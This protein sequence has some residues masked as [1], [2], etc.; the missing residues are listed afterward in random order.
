MA[1][2]KAQANEREYVIPL[3]NE[4]R[5]VANYRRAGRASK[6][7]KKFIAR[8]MRVED[9]DVSKVKLDRYLNNEVW[10]RGKT[11]PP[12]KLKVKA[13]RDG[14]VIRVELAQMPDTHKFAKSRHD[15]RHKEPETK[16]AAPVKQE[17]KEETSEEKKEEQKEKAQAAA[18]L[19]AKQAKQDAKAQE[20]ATSVKEPGYHRQA[21]KK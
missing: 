15:K 7:I 2:K 21:L 17:K 18:E 13:K 10:F 1:E 8:H 5:K 4:W 16:K 14:D 6:E 20:K 12:A 19:H 11:K 3:R 9:R